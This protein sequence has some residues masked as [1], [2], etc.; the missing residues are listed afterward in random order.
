MTGKK[1]SMEQIIKR[2]EGYGSGNNPRKVKAEELAKKEALTPH[3]LKLSTESA[4][5]TTLKTDKE[6]QTVNGE[7]ADNY[8]TCNLQNYSFKD[9]S[10]T[11]EPPIFSISIK[12]DHTVWK[13]ASVDGKKKIEVW[14]SYLGRAT[15]FDKDVLIFA[16]SQLVAGINRGEKASRT[17]VFRARDYLL[18]T[19]KTTTG[20]DYKR[21]EKSLDRLSGTRLKTNIITGNVFIKEG[22]GI[23]ENWKILGSRDYN[24]QEIWIELTL[25]QWVYNSIVSQ[26]ILTINNEY[27]RLSSP[28]E[29]RLY[30]VARKH[31]GKQKKWSIGLKAL[32][33]KCGSVRELRKFKSDL[34]LLSKNNHLP[35]YTYI[36]TDDGIVWFKP[37]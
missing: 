8:F 5:E 4:T 25:S 21:L 13:W 23:V 12:D 6:I 9:D 16:A 26:E 14:P 10:A 11:M 18:S 1:E 20:D 24:T 22:F 33:G 34:K 29:R 37:K 28:I 36:I 17:V 31:V 15:I 27:F 3:E 19:E 7:A 32:Q 35:D 2:M 30:E